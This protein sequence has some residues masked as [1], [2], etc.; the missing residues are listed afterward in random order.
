[1]QASDIQQSF[2]MIN[3]KYR[4]Q[5]YFNALQNVKKYANLVSQKNAKN[6]VNVV[7]LFVKLCVRCVNVTQMEICVRN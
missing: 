5:F 3:D 6:L 7:Q 4:N 1:M 2:N